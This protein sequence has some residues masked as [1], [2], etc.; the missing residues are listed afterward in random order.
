MEEEEHNWFSKGLMD[1]GGKHLARE[2]ILKEAA[3]PIL[4]RR[5]RVPATERRRPRCSMPR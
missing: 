3:K 1:A 2:D 4:P 5:L